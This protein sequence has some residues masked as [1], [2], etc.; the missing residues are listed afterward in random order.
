MKTRLAVAICV[1]AAAC[2]GSKSTPTAPETPTVLQGQTVSAIDG[3]AMVVSVQVGDRPTIQS[4]AEGNFQV[5]VRGAGSYPTTVT[6]RP[7]IERHTNIT[8][9]GADRA[10]LSLIPAAFDLQ[11]FDEMFRG[12]NSRLQRWTSPP[13]LVVVATVMRY[14]DADTDRYEALN[15]RLTDAEVS[16]L[17]SNLTEGLALLTA[18]TYSD[19]AAVDIE[20]PES[21]ERVNVQRVGRIVVGRYRGIRTL[22]QTIGYGT[23]AEQSSG[24]VVGGTMWLDRD[25]DKDDSRRRLL[26][27]H[28]LGHALGY[29]HVTTRPSI[30]NPSIGPEPTDFDRAGSTIAFQRPVGNKSPDTDPASSAGGGP[31]SAVTEGAVRWNPPI[32]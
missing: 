10:R 5:D 4:D 9:P 26:R 2:G 31:T 11:A 17:V 30:M 22:A 12:A 13:S 8:G 27:I 29:N 21:G 3:S 1:A 14:T 24:A 15:E 7:I 6:G 25:F 23:W 32:H 20:R 16:A 28:E 19:F 18:G